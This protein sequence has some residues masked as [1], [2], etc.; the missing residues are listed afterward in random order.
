[1]RAAE[2]RTGRRFADVATLWRW[3]VEDL[4]G[5]WDALWDF[6]AV[7]AETKGGRVLADGDKM[8]GA[9]FFPDAAPRLRDLFD[10]VGQVEGCEV[11]IDDRPVPY[12][13][14]L[15]LPLVWFLIP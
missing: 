2:R 3:S 15:W 14:E 5:F 8:P 12:A 11:L 10:I 13:R 6:S 1:M 4:E 9:R 7:V